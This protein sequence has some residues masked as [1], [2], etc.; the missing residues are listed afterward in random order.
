MLLGGVYF[1]ARAVGEP[2]LEAFAQF[3]PLTP[4]LHALR[5]LL[6]RG[7]TLAEVAPSI[8]RLAIM[9]AILLPAGMLAFTAGVRHAR[10]SGSLTHY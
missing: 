10:R 5:H 3:L 9:A 8:T 1:P 4:A 7:A 6:L 2:A